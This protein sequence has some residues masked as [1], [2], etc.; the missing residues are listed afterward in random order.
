MAPSDDV[1]VLIAGQKR[2]SRSTQWMGAPSTPL[3]WGCH[4]SP[5]RLPVPTISERIQ[6]CAGYVLDRGCQ[7]MP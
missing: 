2:S 4:S 5:S 7:I 6:A 1:P 3:S